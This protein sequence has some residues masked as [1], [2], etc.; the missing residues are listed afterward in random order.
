MTSYP[1]EN[2]NIDRG[3]NRGQYWY[4]MVD[5]DVTSNTA[6][7]NIFLLYSMSFLLITVAIKANARP[8][9]CEKRA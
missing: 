2:I 4:S 7:I 1:P 3:D 5:I 9:Y 8:H 6:I